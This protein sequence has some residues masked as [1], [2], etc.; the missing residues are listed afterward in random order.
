[1]PDFAMCENEECRLRLNCRRFMSVPDDY[2]QD[3]AFFDIGIDGKCEGFKP[4]GQKLKKKLQALR[5][6]EIET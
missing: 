6:K 3:Y 2:A 1:M 5:R 4:M